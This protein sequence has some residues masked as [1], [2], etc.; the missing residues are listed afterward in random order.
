MFTTPRHTAR[1][2]AVAAALFAAA[3]LALT[4]SACTP[5]PSSGAGDAGSSSGASTASASGTAFA[6]C[7]KAAGVT[8]KVDP[9]GRVLV[10]MPDQAAGSQSSPEE[11]SVLGVVADETG[12][13]VAPA[14]PSAFAGQPELEDAFTGCQ[15]KLP[16][17]TQP[18]AG[19]SQ[20]SG[21]SVDETKQQEQVLAF[22]K[23]ARAAG[24][25][26]FTDPAADSGST[27]VSND[28]PTV[29]L[30]E[31]ITADRLRAALKAC[32]PSHPVQFAVGLDTPDDVQAVLGEFTTP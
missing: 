7:L 20:G 17:F 28:G 14:K 32:Y 30:P 16:G 18:E 8:A 13:W 6:A 27:I 1:P 15:T 21:A 26:E 24:F 31:G 10:K 3:G 4:L 5:S 23:C 11:G 25:D 12:F 22:T 2:G 19:A 9:A 29:M